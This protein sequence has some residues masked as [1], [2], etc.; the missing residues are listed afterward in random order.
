MRGGA[1]AARLER[2]LRRR[3]YRAVPRHGARRGR[4]GGKAPRA[5]AGRA[6]GDALAHRRIHGPLRRA[7]LRVRSADGHALRHRLRRDRRKRGSFAPSR[8]ARLRL[9]QRGTFALLRT[10]RTRRRRPRARGNAFVRAAKAARHDTLHLPARRGGRARRIRLRAARC[11]S[12]QLYSDAPRPRP[13]DGTHMRRHRRLPLLDEVRRGV[14][15]RGGARGRRAG[16]RAQRAARRGA[17]GARD[18]L[19]RA[20]FGRRHARQR[21]RAARGRGGATSCRRTR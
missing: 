20:P 10:R 3:I 15:R 6:R 8:G 5:R 2:A 19:H 9:G 7:A 18:T 13:A 12:G 16:A 4:A 14:Q 11:G 17:G 1:R 21:R